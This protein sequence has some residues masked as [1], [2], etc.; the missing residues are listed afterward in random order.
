M[1]VG[2]VEIPSGAELLR[3]THLEPESYFVSEGK[4]IMTIEKEIN[5]IR[6]GSVIYI[7]SKLTHSVKYSGN[8]TLKS[9]FFFFIVTV[10]TK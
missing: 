9:L 7:P 2:I 8:Q 4:G 5:E 1:V 3:H 10:G 6:P